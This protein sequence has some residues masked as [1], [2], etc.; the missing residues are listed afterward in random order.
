[1]K[2]FAFLLFLCLTLSLPISANVNFSGDEPVFVKEFIGQM[3]FVKGRLMQLAE[4]MPEDKYNWTPG[5]GVR[6][7]GEVYVHAAEANFYLVTVMMGTKPDM[8]Q[9]KSDTDKKTALAML[10]KSIDAV[11][12]AAG[13]LTEDDLNREVE[14]FGMK[15]SLRNFMITMLNHNHE[16]LGQSIAYARMNGVVPPWSMK[17]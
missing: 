9:K 4:A 15:F 17:E 7:V 16:H 5:E 13:K 6:T 2:N 8:N 3:D 12:E 14:A 10:E 1:M 11:K